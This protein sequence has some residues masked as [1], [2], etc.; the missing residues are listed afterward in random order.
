MRSLSLFALAAPLVSALQLTRP[1]S[2]SHLEKGESYAVSWTSVSTDPTRFNIYIV[3]YSSY[4]PVA[5]K[6]ASNVQRS[7]GSI[8]V[9]VPCGVR[10]DAGYQL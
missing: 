8:K 5:V 4:P 10:D 9:T 1:A 6:V 2:G 3:N 7:A